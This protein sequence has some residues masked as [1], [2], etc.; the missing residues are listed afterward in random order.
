VQKPSSIKRENIRGG[1]ICEYAVEAPRGVLYGRFKL[2]DDGRI[3][4]CTLITPTAQNLASMED[5]ATGLL[6]NRRVDEGAVDVAKS[7]VVAYDPCISC[8]VHAL[9]VEFLRINP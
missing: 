6:R 4:E 1:S 8:S 3:Q 9:R 7:I 5:T 2:G